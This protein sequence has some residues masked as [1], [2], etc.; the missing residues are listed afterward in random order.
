[1]SPL[2]ALF[3]C[4]VLT[5]AL[6][7]LDHRLKSEV[8]TALWIPTVWMLIIGSRVVSQWLGAG[9]S[10]AS[11]N[12]YVEGS[13]LDRNIYLV[14][15]VMAF[16]VLIVR[17]V[18]FS[19]VAKANG[20]VVLFLTYCGISI[21]WSDFPDV[22]FKRYIKEIGNLLMVLIV[23]SERAP[24][25]AISTLFKRCAY[26]LMPLSVV[27]IK[28]FPAM[29]R[30]Y[31]P[32]TG[33]VTYTGVTNN[34]N[35]LGVLCAVCGIGI[36]WNLLSIWRRN[37]T[38][39]NKLQVFIQGFIL[40]LILWVLMMSH[41]STSLVCFIMGV[42][43]VMV[44]GVKTVRNNMVYILPAVLVLMVGPIYVMTEGSVAFFTGMVGRDETFTGRTEIWQKALEMVEN[45]IIGCGYSSFWLGDRLHAFW[46]QYTWFPTETHN[47]Y[48][49]IYLELGLIGLGLLIGVLISS[50]R[51]ILTVARR[52]VHF[53]ALK[54]AL[55]IAAILYNITESAFRSGLLMYFIFE[56][57]VIQFSRPVHTT[58]MRY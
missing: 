19:Q 11:E 30:S 43:I 3:A 7:I 50:L 16:V 34:K 40:I 28:Y 26:I 42:G 29:G 39:K 52:D 37:E 4:L 33:A 54:L 45:P 5:L 51:A 56:L 41:S 27:L 13:A 53:G 23:L 25:E 31:S 48:L 44:M 24:V 22:S 17:G 57:V 10:Y 20:W 38:S 47:G 14:L 12:A 1:M 6:L 8:S 55:L 21:S 36:A 35:T 15:I 2:I 49:E 46:S 18:S 32:W 9:E 58:N